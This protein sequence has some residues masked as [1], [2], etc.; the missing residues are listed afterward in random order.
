LSVMFSSLL[1]SGSSKVINRP[2]AVPSEGGRPIDLYNAAEC[3]KMCDDFGKI[4]VKRVC[5]IMCSLEFSSAIPIVALPRTRKA[6]DR[7]NP[8]AGIPY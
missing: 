7:D 1:I 3:F 6:I 4:N 5:E 8:P 2:D